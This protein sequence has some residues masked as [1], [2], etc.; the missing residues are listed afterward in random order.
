MDRHRKGAAD[1]LRVAKGRHAPLQRMDDLSA[2][3][4]RQPRVRLDPVTFRQARRIT[5]YRGVVSGTRPPA[6][7]TGGNGCPALS[8]R[9]QRIARS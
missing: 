9:V 8:Y 3:R 7:V 5:R 2:I 1:G 4:S 6:L